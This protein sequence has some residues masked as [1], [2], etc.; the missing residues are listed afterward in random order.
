MEKGRTWSF[1]D[2]ES[3]VIK[4]GI[5]GKC[6]GCVSFCS[7]NRIGALVMDEA[8]FPSYGD[9]DKCLECGL[10]Y[11]VCP[12]THPM[13][14]EVDEHFRWKPPIGNVLDVF[15]ARSAHT[16]VRDRATDG[17]V[18]TS[19]LIHMLDKGLI[20]G[21]VVSVSADPLR[22][23]AVVATTREELLQAA[24]SQFEESPHLEEVGKGY[25]TYVPVV[26][27]IQDIA[28][29]KVRKLAVVGTPCQI[30]AIRKMQILQIT[31]SDMVTFAIGL[32]CMQCFEV[33]N[34]MEKEVIK[35]HKIK[36]EDIAR[37][38]IKEDFVLKMKSG[39]TIHIPLKEIEEIARPACLACRL[40]ANDFAD[41]SVGGLGSPDGY[42]T[43]LIRSIKG[44]EMFADALYNGGLQCISRQS[45]QERAGERQRIVSLVEEFAELKKRRGEAT[46]ERLRAGGA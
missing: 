13:K 19:L 9:K 20:D 24:G 29:K 36:V 34:L 21:A 10:C 5:C 35:S 1:A 26:K 46:L 18:V 33:G 8:G 16:E 14:D 27:S 7:A 23:K 3:E 25:T 22:R 43:V 4:Q 17:G 45:A 44:K 31:P 2:L 40:F 12:Q 28:P 41:I 37:V 38:N 15:S 11:M 42:T 39:I 32:F 6:G 30:D